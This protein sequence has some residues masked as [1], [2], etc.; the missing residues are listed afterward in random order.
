[1]NSTQNQFN[2]FIAP[3]ESYL[4]VSSASREDT[5]GG[6]DYYI[7]FRAED[8][9]WSDPIHLG[10]PVNTPMN[11]EMSPYV[12]PDGRFFL[13]MSARPFPMETLPDTLTWD[14]LKRFRE[15]PET[16]NPGIYWMRADF[17]D[18]LR[19]AGF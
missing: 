10:E 17:I 14:Y 19:P 13:F 6:A 5:M 2:A 1:V 8:D 12:S 18:Q 4:I 11:A 9:R 16:G 15:M 7:V 3:D